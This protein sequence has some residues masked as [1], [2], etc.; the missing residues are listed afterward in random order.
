ME[1]SQSDQQSLLIEFSN[2]IKQVYALYS[3]GQSADMT[4]AM[5]QSQA[6]LEKYANWMQNIDWSV[7][8][9]A[10]AQYMS[11][12]LELCDHFNSQLSAATPIHSDR[13]T[14][15][16]SQSY[17]A[18]RFQAFNPFVQINSSDRRFSNDDWHQLPLFHFWMQQ[19][20][21]LCEHVK[22]FLSQHAPPN[23]KLKKQ[24]NFFTQLWLDAL[25]PSNYPLMNPEVITQI[26]KTQGECVVDGF[27]QF[28]DD[29]IQGKGV[30]YFK[31]TDMQA[32]QVGK[33]LATTKGQVVFKNHLFELIQYDP[34]TP[35]VQA[36]PLLMIPPWINKY[37]I[38]DLQ[39]KNSFVK[40]AVSQG[41]TVFMVS[42]V[43]PDSTY[44]DTTF[45]DYMTKGAITA[46]DVVKAITQQPKINALGFC[47]GGTLLACTLAYLKANN[48]DSII[49]ATFLTSLIDFSDA[50]D[51]SVFLD[52]QQVALLNDLMAREGV[53][54]G[55]RLM[56]TYNLLRANDLFWSFYINNY[57]C[58]KQPFPFDLLF[59]NCDSVNLPYQM[60]QFYLEQMYLKNALIQPNG[61]T[62]EHTPIDVRQIEVPCYF[63]ST[64]KDHIAPWQSTFTG[65]KVIASDVVFVL[66]GSGHV[67]GVVNPPSQQKYSYRTTKQSIGPECEAQSWYE[68]SSHSQGSW[69]THWGHWL[70]TQSGEFVE[71]R[72]PGSEHYPPI[73]PAPGQYVRMTC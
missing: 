17:D 23:E 25:S 50:G 28:M 21:L 40:W 8:I 55:K 13:Q 32:F 69:W 68:Q 20:L 4:F 63:L 9:A 30:P 34:T 5:A 27:K 62:L 41:F 66:G 15:K 49:C 6:I 31:M 67:A 51:V 19:Y 65:A 73:Y 26:I 10:Q 36:V 37:Y 59:W 14:E 47:I 54:D 39:E 45:A 64:E 33:N 48:Q 43:N 16:L 53:L 57:L 24:I 70:Q 52:E 18:N 1:T 12:F 7:C 11:A 38:L 71:A 58:G 3:D 42:W 56:L 22:K 61:I 46:I 29:L 60:H 2:L 35:K 44:R 72:K